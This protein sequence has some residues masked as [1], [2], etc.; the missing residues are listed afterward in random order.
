MCLDCREAGGLCVT[1]SLAR[2]EYER[3]RNE[4]R[5]R[6]HRDFLEYHRVY[7]RH[8]RRQKKEAQ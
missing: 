7:Q 5:E 2:L 6:R 4:E 1:C 8:W 3:D